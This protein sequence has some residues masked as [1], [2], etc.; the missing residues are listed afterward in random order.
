[1]LIIATYWTE[2]CTTRASVPEH[3]ST[4]LVK[5]D[6]QGRGEGGNHREY[7]NTLRLHHF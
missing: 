1:M 5:S 6:Q 2:V 3:R 4:S 7:E